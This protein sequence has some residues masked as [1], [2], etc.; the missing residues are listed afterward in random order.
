MVD[1][2]KW[3]KWCIMVQGG[4]IVRK[5]ELFHMCGREYGGEYGEKT[6][7]LKLLRGGV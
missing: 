2:T 3:E 4:D 1:L 6:T 7:F 5:E